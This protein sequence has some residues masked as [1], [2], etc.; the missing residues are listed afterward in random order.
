MNNKNQQSSRWGFWVIAAVVVVIAILVYPSVSRIT[1]NDVAVETRE[2]VNRY[3]QAVALCYE[4]MNR[5]LKGCNTGQNGIPKAYTSWFNAIKSIHVY[6]GV[7]QIRAKMSLG[8][9]IFIYYIPR[10]IA[11]RFFA[12]ST[13][14]K[15]SISWQRIERQYCGLNSDTYTCKHFMGG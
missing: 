8:E 2:K 13:N 11:Q 4:K 6:R 5:E 12:T 3:Q 14:Q 10:P 7:I 1:Q 15:S 9:P